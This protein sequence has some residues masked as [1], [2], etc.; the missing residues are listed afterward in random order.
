MPKDTGDLGKDIFPPITVGWFKIEGTGDLMTFRQSLELVINQYV[1]RDI[2]FEIK[3]EI[4]VRPGG[5]YP[6]G[7][8]SKTRG[9]GE[10]EKPAGG[11]IQS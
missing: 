4:I 2:I 11:G 9:P 10:A 5:M 6:D 1:G 3:A 8:T 7:R